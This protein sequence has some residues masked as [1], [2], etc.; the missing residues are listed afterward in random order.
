MMELIIF[1][2]SRKF[3]IITLILL[4]LKLNKI[5]QSIKL[6]KATIIQD[7]KEIEVK[8]DSIIKIMGNKD[9]VIL[10]IIITN[11]VVLEVD[12]EVVLILEGII[13]ITEM[14]TLTMVMEFNTITLEMLVIP[15]HILQEII[16]HLHLDSID[17]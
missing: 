5:L 9:G 17:V 1:G 14:I 13:T 10:I 11:L 6:F 15:Y 12:I 8:V 4:L 2:V 16:Y 7:M 3:N